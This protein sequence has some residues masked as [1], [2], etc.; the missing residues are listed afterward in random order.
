MLYCEQ[1]VDNLYMNNPSSDSMSAGGSEMYNIPRFIAIFVIAV[2]A[3]VMLMVFLSIVLK[4]AL[5]AA[6]VA[7]AYYWFTRATE[8]RRRKRNW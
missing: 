6:L 5:L 1:V 4:L 7:L 3:F 2:I 8:T